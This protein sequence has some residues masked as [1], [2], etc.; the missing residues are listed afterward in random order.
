MTWKNP[1]SVLVVIHTPALG[2]LLL[3]RARHPGFWQSVTGSQ[4]GGESLLETA[5]REVTE[6]T[7]IAA[8]AADFLD[9]RQTNCYEIFAEWRYRY[10][11]DVTHNT[12]HVYSL[13]VP[14]G[15]PVAVADEEHLGY[16]WLPWREAATACFSWTNRDAI[17]ALPA[18][19]DQL[20][21][22]AP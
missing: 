18:R 6:E 14:E 16:R 9:W 22:M 17:L 8:P 10:A 13:S 4:E 3:E 15:C 12:E 2:V 5:C 21:L 11:P 1:V 7:G 19:L 20:H